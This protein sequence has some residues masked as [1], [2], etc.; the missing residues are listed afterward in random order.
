MYLCVCM[1]AYAPAHIWVL[2]H[3]LCKSFLS[4]KHVD[5][6]DSVLG[7][8][9]WLQIP[10][11]SQYPFFLC[12]IRNEP[13]VFLHVQQAYYHLATLLVLVPL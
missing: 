6:Q 11:P 1:L 8:Q 12:N 9:A 13:D 2:E 7:P 3:N 4:F 5:F 10:L